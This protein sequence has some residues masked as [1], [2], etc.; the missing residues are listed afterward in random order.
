M[1]IIL[2]FITLDIYYIL[3]LTS[4]CNVFVNN[5][6]FIFLNNIYIYIL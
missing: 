5:C 3:I 1:I 6:M 4:L 2:Y